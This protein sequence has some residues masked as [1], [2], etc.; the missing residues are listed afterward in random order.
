M[1]SDWGTYCVKKL[2]LDGFVFSRG[3]LF[4]S[5]RCW[6]LIAIS[7]TSE[8]TPLLLHQLSYAYLQ[9]VS[10]LTCSVTSILEN[11]PSYDIRN[12]M[13][14]TEAMLADLMDEADCSPYLMLDS[15]AVL[16]MQK[17]LRAKIGSCLRRSGMKNLLFGLLIGGG[18]Q[19]IH[20]VRGRDRILH[21]SDCLLLLNFLTNSLSLRSS[22]ESWTPICLPHF[23][24]RGFLYAYICYLTDDI[25]LTLLTA[26]SGDFANL[27]LA[28]T[29]IVEGQCA[30]S[31]ETDGGGMLFHFL[32]SVLC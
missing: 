24:N 21:P 26:D 3:P 17:Q 10:V 22:E 19:L 5:C 31:L 9:M 12:L 32:S 28:K 7:R 30:M 29:K 16:R 4:V 20:I 6:Q 18:K 23:S 25:C 14:G 11:K 8:S 15:I 27:R 1:P 2:T 13:Q